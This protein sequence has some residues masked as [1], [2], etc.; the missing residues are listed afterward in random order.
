MTELWTG[1]PLGWRMGL[2]SAVTIGVFDGVHRGHRAVLADV[3]GRARERDLVPVALTFD[4]H[5]L[6]FLDPGHA[7]KLLGTIEHRVE[8]LW[9][10]GVET[11]GVLPFPQIRDL[12]P[13]V[14]ACEVLADRLSARLVAVGGDF[15]FGRDR[16]GDIELLREAGAAAG[17][18]VEP[19]SLVAAADGEIVS[20]SR[21]RDL[22]AAGKLDEVNRLLGRRFELRG[23]VI[24]GDVRGRKIGFPTA[25]LHIP[26]RLAV[27]QYGVYAAWASWEGKEAPAVVNIGVRPTFGE[28][29]RMVEAH[30]IDFDGD[31]Y[32]V[33]MTLR[34]VERLREER[35]FDGIDALVQQIGRDRDAAAAI[36]AV[37]R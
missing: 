36:L 15:R 3:V 10:C 25:N 26:D 23:P 4:P 18:V 16:Q 29:R 33:D 14:F 21:I 32:G 11:V 9:E 5:P 24:H 1:D 7:P 31:L 19:V 2:P 27:P 20:S 22:L 35:R 12:A 13:D 17:F 28:D 8:L 6:E 30:L 34:F 37:D